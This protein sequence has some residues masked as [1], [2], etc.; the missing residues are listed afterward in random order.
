MITARHALS[1]AILALASFASSAAVPVDHARENIATPSAK[2][3]RIVSLNL[4]TDQ[5]LLQMVEPSR[6]RAVSY[7]ARDPRSS[8]MVA[9]AMRVAET[10]GSAEE[11]VAMKP[12]LVLAGTYSTR[13]TVAILR[14]LGYAVVEFEP[15]SNFDDIIGN[16]RKLA[17]A[18]GEQ[19]KGEQM[20]A[21]IEQHLSRL[22]PAPRPRPV[23]ANYDANGYSSGD[24]T[25]IAAVANLAGFD[26]LAQRL[27][28]AGSPQIPLEQMLTSRPD[29]I[30]PGD[31]F[32]APSLATE[33]LGHPALRALMQESRPIDLHGKYTAC[34]TMLTLEALDRLVAAREAL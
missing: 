28:L 29:I 14:Q 8:G 32:A 7:L 4:C 13:Q 34:G 15:E 25:L 31:D 10:R 17:E 23:Y 16:I 5:L 2:P 30:D 22:P 12:D 33:M 21:R 20:V 26:T 3:Q 6:I 18:V 1:A 9:Q 24:G 19:A 27:D 11:I